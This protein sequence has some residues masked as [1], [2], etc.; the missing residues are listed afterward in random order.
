MV[1]APAA[2]LNL[3]SPGNWDTNQ[4]LAMVVHSS[5][6]PSVKSCIPL[7]TRYH[8]DIYNWCSIPITCSTKFNEN[9]FWKVWGLVAF[10]ILVELFL[11]KSQNFVFLSLSITVNIYYKM[12]GKSMWPCK[13]SFF[14]CFTLFLLL[15]S[16]TEIYR[17]AYRQGIE[18]M[19]HILIIFKCSSW[20]CEYVKE[21]N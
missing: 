20:K 14:P 11:L 21:K 2:I 8:K 6:K 3:V 4:C 12:D 10:K 17:L 5:L 18:F 19:K 9:A 7:V 15:S 16:S 1:L 13:R